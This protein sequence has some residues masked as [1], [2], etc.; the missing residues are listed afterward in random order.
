MTRRGIPLLTRGADSSASDGKLAGV[1]EGDGELV[2]E[3][4]RPV[5]GILGRGPQGDDVV[6]LVEVV[7][8]GHGH[9]R[10]LNGLL[11]GEVGTIGQVAG[12]NDGYED[13]RAS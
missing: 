11:D 5:A 6:V 7:R 1:V 10:I 9:P 4:A 2:G 13:L 3:K 8:A 12:V